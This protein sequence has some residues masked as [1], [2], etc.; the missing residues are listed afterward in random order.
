MSGNDHECTGKKYYYSII[1]VGKKGK[2][3]LWLPSLIN[4]DFKNVNA[5]ILCWLLTKHITDL[6]LKWTMIKNW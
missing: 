1:L 2:I 6:I 4:I 5:F 3:T